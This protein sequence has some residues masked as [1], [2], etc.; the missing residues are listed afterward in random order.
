MGR[1][2]S[3]L[4]RRARSIKQPSIDEMLSK[5]EDYEIVSF[6]VFDTLI[7]RD[8]ERSV[9]V[10]A[11]VE[12]ESPQYAG[13]AALR[14]GA[15]KSARDAAGEHEVT[16]REIYETLARAPEAATLPLEELKRAELEAEFALIEPNLPMFE[17]FNKLKGAGKRIVIVSDT[18]LSGD[19]VAQLLGK[20]GYAGWERLFVSSE[21]GVRKR[22][23]GLFRF[24]LR[25]L[26]FPASEIIHFGDS[27]VE[28]WRRPRS[29]GMG[30]LRVPTYR[31][32][33][34]FSQGAEPSVLGDGCARSLANNKAELYTEDFERFGYEILGPILTGFC[35]WMYSDL[36]DKG[37]KR[38][39]FLS[40]DG[41]LIKQVFERLGFDKEIECE[42]LYVSR[43][44]L[45]TCALYGS[46]WEEDVASHISDSDH[47]PK[48]SVV[49]DN[50]GLN[51]EEQVPACEKFCLTLDTEIPLSE[52]KSDEKFQGLIGEIRGEVD[53]NSLRQRELF[54]SYLGSIG[55]H[56]H[57][58]IVDI[59]WRGTMQDRLVD[60]C[61]IAGI[62][63]QIQGYY[64]G[65]RY[66]AGLKKRQGYL[67]S[68]DHNVKDAAFQKSYITPTELMFL[69]DH[70][71]VRG[72]GI[73][74][75]GA[76]VPKL[77]PYEYQGLP[78][79]A[80]NIRS[81]QDGSVSF[82]A[83][84]KAITGLGLCISPVYAIELLRNVFQDPTKRVLRMFGDLPFL[85]SG[86]Y[87]KVIPD[88]S[89][90]HLSDF[91]HKFEI[92]AWKAGF[93][94]KAV[95][96]SWLQGLFVRLL[97]IRKVRNDY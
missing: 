16:L 64:V 56:G 97:Y 39:F 86:S 7:K 21:A 42:Y 50:L 30:A 15:E 58:A 96:L 89:L 37:I 53:K 18:Y 55:F 77:Y 2:R 67:F 61:G 41:Y 78:E 57:V 80:N 73:N 71:S 35:Q 47:S 40:R 45:R 52:M 69:A 43:Q 95:H 60:I 10:F 12:S 90:I 5:A 28:D 14:K 6:D 26:D 19:F 13:F 48:L 51:P 9:D 91:M 75:E 59:G 4:A 27:P 76:F 31:E 81:L 22:E 74:D 85:E 79:T 92:C 32:N 70:G 33:L 17:L 82:A 65:L 93:L 29:L 46:G 11:V 66:K 38:V 34:R 84:A 68:A 20:C 72:Y 87:Q 23:G 24:V 25:E 1:L 62:D 44:S 3:I 36:Q 49:L 83:A 54:I 94:K 63:A 8:V 88:A